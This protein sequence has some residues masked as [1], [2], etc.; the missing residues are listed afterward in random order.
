MDI[1]NVKNYKITRFQQTDD[2]WL[3]SG[4]DCPDGILIS[5]AFYAGKLPPSFNWIWKKWTL[6]LSSIN[7]FII[8]ASLNEVKLFEISED[9]YPEEVKAFI[10]GMQELVKECKKRKAEEVKRFKQKVTAYLSTFPVNQRLEE[11]LSV[12]PVCLRAYCKLHLF[13]G[14]RTEDK[15]QRLSLMFELLKVVNRWYNRYIN[16]DHFLGKIAMSLRFD[17]ARFSYLD[18]VEAYRRRATEEHQVL[19]QDYDEISELISD[20]L[21]SLEDDDVRNYLIW[22]V[23]ELTHLYADDYSHLDCNYLQDA[24]GNRMYSDE[25]DYKR[26]HSEMKLPTYVNFILPET[27]SEE[28]LK[29]FFQTYNLK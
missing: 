9:N 8:S 20:S 24:W 14:T 11:E 1:I 28:K 22:L 19:F 4:P 13:C 21:P 17:G 23:Q 2:G 26:L 25:G 3:L 27:I 7:D 16:E 12:L 10:K 15:G 5:K 18:D 29:K 6:K